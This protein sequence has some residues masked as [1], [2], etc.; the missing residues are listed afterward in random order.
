[1]LPGAEKTGHWYSSPSNPAEDSWF[2]L[3][4]DIVEG[5]F[6]AIVG[7]LS[8]KLEM[9]QEIAQLTSSGENAALLSCRPCDRLHIFAESGLLALPMYYKNLRPLEHEDILATADSWCFGLQRF[10]CQQFPGD[11][12]SGIIVTYTDDHALLG[13]A[14]KE[15]PAFFEHYCID[16]GLSDLL[17]EPVPEDE[18]PQKPSRPQS[19]YQIIS[20]RI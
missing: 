5:E 4:E 16:K 7:W 3:P 2:I 6:K 14:A 9:S 19:W 18:K 10:L 1:M 15:S 8:S 17:K 12:P 13:E 11:R 20:K